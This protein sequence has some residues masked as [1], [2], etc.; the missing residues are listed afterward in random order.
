MIRIRV[1][2]S[3][4]LTNRAIL[5]AALAKG[6]S[7]LKGA[8]ESDDTKYM[9][10]ALKKLGI[11]ILKKGNILKIQGG[12]LT[13]TPHSLFC[14]N[15]GTTMRFLAAVLA[16]QSFT[17][18]LTGSPRMK[19]RPIGDLADAL[20]S[21]GAKIQFIGE[22]GFP[23]IQI[24]GPLQGGI[25]HIKGDVSSQFLSGL[26]MATPLA[27]KNVTIKVQGELVSKPYIDMTLKL[28][29]KFGVS[30]N[31]K[32]Y[33]EFSI[34]AGQRYKPTSMNIEGDASSASYF[35][36]IS[37]LTG[38][39]I[40][41]ENVTQDSSQADAAFQKI[42]MAMRQKDGAL[43]PLGKI[44][45]S[46]FPDSA[47]TL[48]VLCAF[49]EGKSELHGLANLRVKECD[50]LHALATELRKIGTRVDEL[51]DGL[52]IHGD[53]QT[54]HGGVIGTYDD[55]RM[56]M[57]FGM[58]GF[59][60][61]GIIIKNPACVKKTYPN[62]WKDLKWLK[63]KIAE[64]N[65]I[66]TGMRGSGKSSLGKRLAKA[67]NRKFFDTDM[68]I[69]EIAKKK[70]S[71]IV[72]QHGWGKFRA[73]ERKIVKKL[74]KIKR[75]VISTGGGTLMYSANVQNLKKSG[76]VIFLESSMTS[77]KKRLAKSYHR[78]NLTKKSNFLDELE[79]IYKQRKPR[80]DAVSDATVDVSKSTARSQEDFN[81]KIASIIKIIERWGML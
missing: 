34:C 41:V 76:R 69:E 25:C 32:G 28:M 66:L 5:A 50:R 29:Q 18:K 46:N 19:K 23:P 11:R 14:G 42:A 51:D 33:Q 3:K 13:A 15:A 44:N 20:Q 71:E 77:L 65:I 9:I 61:P 75:A 80:Y 43:K 6:K 35:W 30:V 7:Q 1:P 49:A 2:G 54:L 68:L 12:K 45:A 57:C 16:T 31:R 72:A 10:Q 62:F 52:R 78:P 21:L 22:N 48:A 53:P 79:D 47:M 24:R 58:A 67:M 39:A 70:I 40:E 74:S 60:V 17:S 64:K 73:L 27:Q 55:H 59:A 56:A 4:S 81:K 63:Q 37:A 36:G 26:L 38:Q 8:L